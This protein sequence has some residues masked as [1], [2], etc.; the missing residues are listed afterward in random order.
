MEERGQ[1][2]ELAVPVIV[3]KTTVWS[4]S[5]GAKS[6]RWKQ[7]MNEIDD[8]EDLL[9]TAGAF[10]FQGIYIDT[11]MYEDHSCDELVQELE[12]QLGEPLVCNENRRYFFSMSDYNKKLQE[13]YTDEQMKTVREKIEEQF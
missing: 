11:L 7:V 4:N 8:V 12:M 3:S 13:T 5:G 9:L 1:A 6:A 2:Y 10:G